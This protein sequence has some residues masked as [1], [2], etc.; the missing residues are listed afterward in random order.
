MLEGERAEIRAHLEGI[1]QALD[2]LRSA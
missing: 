2:A 1:L